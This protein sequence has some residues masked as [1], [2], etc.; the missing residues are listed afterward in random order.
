VI[1]KTVEGEITNEFP[2]S[3]MQTHANGF[4]MIDEEAASLLDQKK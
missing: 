2:A 3:I 4:V 1:K